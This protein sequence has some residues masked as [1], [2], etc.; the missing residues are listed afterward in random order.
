[1]EEVVDHRVEEEAHLVET[2]V[3]TTEVDHL[4]DN[5]SDHT[6]V[7]FPVVVVMALGVHTA[8]EEA[9]QVEEEAH[10]VDHQEVSAGRTRFRTK[11]G[12]RHHRGLQTKV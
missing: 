7:L 4:L 10:Q 8:E 12:W 11:D 2:E 5:H 6:E 1:M 9:R 3:A